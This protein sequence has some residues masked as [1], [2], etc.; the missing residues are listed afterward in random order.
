MLSGIC[1]PTKALDK[2]L[3]LDVGP[4]SIPFSIYPSKEY[5]TYMNDPNQIRKVYKD[6]WSAV[7][8]AGLAVPKKN[9][10][11]LC[12]NSYSYDNVDARLS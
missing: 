4:M 7:A 5:L 8:S 3:K 9:L 11:I 1:R 12:V 2:V 6:L 10:I